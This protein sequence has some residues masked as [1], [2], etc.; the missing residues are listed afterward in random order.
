MKKFFGLF[1]AIA[2][3]IQCC[4][5][6]AAKSGETLPTYSTQAEILI[7][8]GII[9]DYTIEQYDPYSYIPNREFLVNAQQLYGWFDNTRL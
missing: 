7:N 2:I 4:G 6:L 8:L 1:I 5:A 9:N 3:V